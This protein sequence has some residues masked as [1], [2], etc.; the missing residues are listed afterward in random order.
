M[1]L[2]KV[3]SVAFIALCVAAT[4]QVKNQSAVLGACS[5][6]TPTS[7]GTDP[8]PFDGNSSLGSTFNMIKCGLDYAQASVK[9]GQRYGLSCCPNTVGVAQPAAFTIAGIPGTAVIERAYLWAGTS[10]NGIAINVSITN[11]LV[12]TTNYP[13]PLIG[14]DQDKCWGFT[15][16]MT[17][18]A[19]VTSCISGNGNYIISGF[20]TSTTQSGND[21]DGATLMVIWSDPTA[22]FQGE[23]HIW[24]G[25]YVG[26]GN[27]FSFTMTGFTACDN[28]SSGA[29]FIISADHQQINSGF[30]IN[31]GAPFTI[32]M[33]ED[34]YN[35]ITAPTSVTLGQ[36]TANY[37]IQASG[38]CYNWMVMGLYF[39]TQNCTSCCVPTGTINVTS[40]VTTSG[41]NPCTGT[42]TATP[43]SGTPP[44]S[45]AW[46]TVPQQTTQTAT[47]L[48]PGTYI[49]NVVD[50][51]CNAGPDTI[52][53]LVSSPVTVTTTNINVLCFG[54]ATATATANPAG[55]TA[56]FTYVWT[57]SAQTGQTA[58]G[59]P[60]G[61]YTVTITDAAGCTV[62]ST[63]TITQPPLLTS[64]AAIAT[65]VTCFGYTDGT[66]TGSG[67]GGNGPYTFLWTPSGQ[68]TQ[69]AAALAAGTYTIIVTDANGCTATD[70]VLVTSPPSMVLGT[71][72]TPASCNMPN[73][74]A[75]ITAGN[76]PTPFTYLWSPSG[77][78]GTTA[79][80]LAAGTYIITVTDANGC[81]LTTT[82]TIIDNSPVATIS[83]PVTI[84]AGDNT[85]LTSTGGGI[86]TWTPI[87]D[88]SCTNCPNP[89][90][91]P[92]VTTQ[93]CVTVTDA[94]GCTDSKCTMVT[95]EYPCPDN[96]EFVAPNAFSPNRDGKNDIFILQ[97]LGLC[98]KD[99]VLTIYDR[100]GEMVFQTTN[101]NLGWDGTHHG[102]LLDPGVFTYFMTATL[103]NT[104]DELIKK[105]NVTLIR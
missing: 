32:G 47:G 23:M 78:T 8:N 64:V 66:A 68:S 51:T 77:G 95:V 44:Y 86:Y 27:T 74:I 55:G 85:A 56:P 69:N 35:Y 40:T 41:C 1:K 75:N 105:G 31:G 10:G 48:C 26:I 15:G 3:L 81:T 79:T 87:T 49:V 7:T 88:L 20:P 76:G 67:A 14:Q 100:W 61:I 4:A 97:G 63:V 94:N 52:T 19:D 72:V 84:M 46:N 60:A 83:P 9:L 12:V 38:D 58:S 53:I 89:T 6:P 103:I 29:G 5:G 91:N 2:Y 34:W 16:T 73:G 62:T 36:T 54:Q 90:A 37:Q 11:P 59:L 43:T 17:Y 57:P 45:Y 98:F 70:T 102:K 104:G 28:S 96:P 82:A 24:D 30:V 18:R 65:N 25:C 93:Y 92:T 33:Q 101:S 71:T 99:F 50:A 80:G 42:A 13:V 39:V 22:T 21:T